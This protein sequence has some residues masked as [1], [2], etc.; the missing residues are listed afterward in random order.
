[1]VSLLQSCGDQ[2]VDVMRKNTVDFIHRETLNVSSA[3]HNSR[4]AAFR[5]ECNEHKSKLDKQISDTI[6]NHRAFMKKRQER[7]EAK[8]QSLR[9]TTQNAIT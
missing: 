8:L 7:N 1:M 3:I 4:V 9:N 6:T 2:R 5:D